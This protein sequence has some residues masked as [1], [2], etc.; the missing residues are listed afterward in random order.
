MA[1]DGTNKKSGE[2]RLVKVNSREKSNKRYD[3]FGYEIPEEAPERNARTDGAAEYRDGFAN[4]N[5]GAGSGITAPGHRYNA[6]IRAAIESGAHRRPAENN[7]AQRGYRDGAGRTVRTGESTYTGGERKR[8]S[9]AETRDVRP[10]AERERND[11][12]RSGTGR[13]PRG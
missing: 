3:A 13:A 8:D 6:D 1:N 7:N 10:S 5:T 4:E 12:T 9:R 11:G 2:I